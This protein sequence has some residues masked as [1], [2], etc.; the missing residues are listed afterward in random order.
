MI[1]LIVWFIK[2]I[3]SNYA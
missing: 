1:R 3:G 2:L